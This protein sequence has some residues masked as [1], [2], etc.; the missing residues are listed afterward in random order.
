MFAQGGKSIESKRDSEEETKRRREGH[1]IVLEN[2][3]E[4]DQ[5]V[6]VE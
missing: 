3:E 5:G 4:T 1:K 2:K 6:C